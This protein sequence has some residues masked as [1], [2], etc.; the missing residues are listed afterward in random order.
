MTMRFMRS[1]VLLGLGVLVISWKM[2]QNK[3]KSLNLVKEHRLKDH[4]NSRNNFKER[5]FKH[6]NSCHSQ[7]NKIK[8]ITTTTKQKVS[9]THLVHS[10][11]AA[12]RTVSSSNRILSHS[13]PKANRTKRLSKWTISS[14]S[15]DFRNNKGWSSTIMS[16]KVQ[17][18]NS[19]EISLGI[20]IIKS[21]LMDCRRGIEMRGR[22]GLALLWKKWTEA[23]GICSTIIWTVR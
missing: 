1:L 12:I 4:S 17:N 19:R 11:W 9:R 15:L 23:R 14:M 21:L 10:K 16:R 13:F 3:R 8:K 20:L 22:K 6:T 7:K 2:S 18:L 5:R